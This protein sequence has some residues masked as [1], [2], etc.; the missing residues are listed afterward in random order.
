MGYLSGTWAHETLAAVS[1]VK[2]RIDR[3]ETEITRMP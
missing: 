2:A 1:I 3:S